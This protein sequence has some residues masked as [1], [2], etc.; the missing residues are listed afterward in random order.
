MRNLH[1]DHHGAAL[2]FQS[3]SVLAKGVARENQMQDPTIMAW[4]QNSDEA[5]PPIY[6]GADPDSWWAKYGAGNGGK[7]EV[8]IG[9]DYQFIMMDA[10]GYET[11]GEIPLRNL[12]DGHGNEYLCYT[13]M[14]GKSTNKPTTEACTMLDGWAANQY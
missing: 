12:S 8:C 6:D 13:P 3:A 11:L 5:M 1:I 10:R 4:H 9:D 14:L 7:L 2:N